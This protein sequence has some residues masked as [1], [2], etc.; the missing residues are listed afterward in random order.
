MIDAAA[1]VGRF[2]VCDG[3]YTIDRESFCGTVN[4]S[5]L[6]GRGAIFH[7]AVCE[8]RAVGVGVG[9]SNRAALYACGICKAAVDH[10]VIHG[11]TAQRSAVAVAIVADDTIAVFK[12]AIL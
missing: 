4:A 8:S 3:I 1:L 9:D 11:C 5:A 2:A 12:Y 7:P 10:L 6:V